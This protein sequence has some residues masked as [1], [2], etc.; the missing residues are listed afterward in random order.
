MWSCVP[1]PV[2]CDSGPRPDGAGQGLI[3]RWESPNGERPP[4]EALS[5]NQAEG[6]K[7]ITHRNTREQ[8]I[9]ARGLSTTRLNNNKPAKTSKQSLH[10]Q[11]H[12][13][14]VSAETPQGHHVKSKKLPIHETDEHKH[15]HIQCLPQSYREERW[16]QYS[17]ICRNK[18][19]IITGSK[20]GT[21]TVGMRQRWT[22]IGGR[23]GLQRGVVVEND[24]IQGSQQ[25]K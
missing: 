5:I 16:T 9:Q 21:E 23:K 24:K 17:T 22:R 10:C 4:G 18:T 1:H 7:Y 3:P 15:M 19:M 14:S 20:K 6:R 12:F 11:L 13:C 2:I 25:E 8:C